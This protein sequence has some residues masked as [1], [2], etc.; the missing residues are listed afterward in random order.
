MENQSLWQRF[1]ANV[2]LR[3]AFVLAGLIALLYFAS[4]MISL[5]LLTFIFTFL[6]LRIVEL[7]QKR[8]NVPT[9]LIVLL[10]YAFL[11]FGIYLAVTIYVPQLASQSESIVDSVLRF[12]K[13]PSED[14]SVI[15][16]YVS[17][18]ISQ[19]DIQ[20]Q[21]S[22]GVQWLFK[23]ISTVSSM[24]MTLAMSLLLSFFFT[25]EKDHLYAFFKRFLQGPNAWLFEDI[26][27]FGGIFTR[28]F[29]LVLETQLLIAVINTSLTTFGLYLMGINQLLSLALMIFILSLIPVAGVIISAVPLSF[30]A[31]YAGGL[32]DVIY[33]LV[34]LIVIHALESYF[35]NPKLM[36]NK[37]E[38]P[39]FLTFVTL[40]VSEHFFGVW[41]LLVGV[42]TLLFAI[43]VLGVNYSTKKEK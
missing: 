18:Y 30:I 35:L 22:N 39:I 8:V 33:V 20:T 3:R 1:L 41:G 7:I 4:S 36:S 15:L 16:N 38:L 21:V 27:Y 25:L 10:V 31:Y 28:N 40:Y 12:Y 11:I 32:Q 34:L 14:T 5:M 2:R 9:S 24:G 43:D 17:Q 13:N 29:G 42:P 23:S 37:T 19:S 26:Y 6:V